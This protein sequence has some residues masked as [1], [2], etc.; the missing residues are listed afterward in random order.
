M[1]YGFIFT[2]ISMPETTLWKK[3]QQF[4]SEVAKESGERIPKPPPMPRREDLESNNKRMEK[5]DICLDIWNLF[6]NRKCMI[7]IYI[8]GPNYMI[9]VVYHWF[10]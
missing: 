5:C 9:Y 8:D 3:Q 1:A 6:G 7:F 4:N 10:I 2:E